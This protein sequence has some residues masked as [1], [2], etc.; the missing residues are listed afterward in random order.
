M[1]RGYKV[2]SLTAALGLALATTTGL[3]AQQRPDSQVLFDERGVQIERP[4]PS[5]QYQGPVSRS[6]PRNART[7][8]AT[9]LEPADA[10][11]IT[12]P[13]RARVKDPRERPTR[14]LGRV[15]VETGSFG[16]ETNKKLKSDQFPDGRPLPGIESQ[17]R[18]NNSPFLGLSISVPTR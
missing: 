10:T 4:A 15:P 3:Q 16:F 11:S 8:P 14:P 17:R 7:A 12:A 6:A 9:T 18:E 1:S 2:A 13:E 5:Q